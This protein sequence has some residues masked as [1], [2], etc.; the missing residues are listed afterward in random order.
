MH[1]KC[2]NGFTLLELIVVVN[3]I[4]ILT[5]IGLPYLKNY[6]LSSKR[7]EAITGLEQI[8]SAQV[9]LH[10]E[11]NFFTT[12][13]TSLHI[14]MKAAPNGNNLYCHAGSAV[15]CGRYYSFYVSD[16]GQDAFIV[17]AQGRPEAG[18]GLDEFFVAYPN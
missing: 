8:Y 15:A 10:S 7:V 12:D 13:L 2:K 9:M 5:A 4:A 11:R 18:A 16:V 3:I 6:Q 17:H 14:N 1:L